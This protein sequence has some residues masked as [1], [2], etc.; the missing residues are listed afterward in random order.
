MPHR[1]KLPKKKTVKKEVEAKILK[2][3][4]HLRLTFLPKDESSV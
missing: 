3:T 2:S 1:D 4:S